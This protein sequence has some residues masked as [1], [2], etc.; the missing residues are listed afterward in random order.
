MTPQRRPQRL[1]RI[2]SA[3]NLKPSV[4]ENLKSIGDLTEFTQDDMQSLAEEQ[5][6]LDDVTQ[7]KYK[8]LEA[9]LSFRAVTTGRFTPTSS[10]SRRPRNISSDCPNRVRPSIWSCQAD[11]HCSPSFPL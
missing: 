7:D 9:D 11:I 3:E 8:G 4:F 10:R 1:S 2:F 6:D 5:P